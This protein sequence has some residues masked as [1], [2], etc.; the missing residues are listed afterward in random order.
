MLEIGFAESV[1]EILAASYSEDNPDK[2]QMLLFSGKVHF[3]LCELCY[4]MQ[5]QYASKNLSIPP[6]LTTVGI[7]WSRPLCDRCVTVVG[8]SLNRSI[9]AVGLYK[10][11]VR[12]YTIIACAAVASHISG[13]AVLVRCI[14]KY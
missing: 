6:C 10:R 3:I 7:V 8:P 9:S 11:G 12:R 4:C 5:L 14:L 2:P 1:E 13:T